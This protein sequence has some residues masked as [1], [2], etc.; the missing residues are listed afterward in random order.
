VLDSNRISAVRTGTIVRID[1]S[2]ASRW[3]PRVVD[4]VRG[5]ASALRSQSG[6]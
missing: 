6:K 2:I 4:F 1:D 5:V 3:G